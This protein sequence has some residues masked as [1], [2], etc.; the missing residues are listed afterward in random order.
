MPP[1]SDEDRENLVAYLDGELDDVAARAVEARINV[2]QHLRAEVEALKQAWDMLDYLPRPEPSST[3]THR[4]L[5]RLEV[6]R[7]GSEFTK[8]RGKFGAAWL[9]PLAWGAALLLAL[10]SSFGLAVWLWPRPTPS[11]AAQVDEVLVEELR[12]L[13]NKRLYDQIEDL[14]FLKQLDD[15]DL[16]RDEAP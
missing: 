1:L 2:D 13:E 16:F 5:E 9:G 11:A 14:E 12:L 15:P 10:G 8:A 3:F 4:T 7:R 6:Q